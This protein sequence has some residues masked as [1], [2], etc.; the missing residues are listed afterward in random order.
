MK[1]FDKHAL[2]VGLVIGSVIGAGYLNSE[3][4]TN[5]AVQGNLYS[6]FERRANFGIE[7]VYSLIEVAGPKDL[8]PIERNDCGTD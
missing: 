6:V 4:S 1:D 3:S 7:I 8:A 5:F 2:T